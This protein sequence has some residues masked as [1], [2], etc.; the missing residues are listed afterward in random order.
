MSSNPGQP[1][2][3]CVTKTDYKVKPKVN[4]FGIPSFSFHKEKETNPCDVPDCPQKL[5]ASN[6]K[7]QTIGQSKKP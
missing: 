5:K 6:N 2:A 7:E 1:K 3:L 4:S